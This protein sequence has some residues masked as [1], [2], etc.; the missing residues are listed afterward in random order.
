MLMKAQLIKFRSR[1]F[2]RADGGTSVCAS[3]VCFGV[4]L[5]EARD[6]DGNRDKGRMDEPA[7]V[8]IH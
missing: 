8:R 1:H 2:S 4:R 6:A 7:C 3:P 5:E